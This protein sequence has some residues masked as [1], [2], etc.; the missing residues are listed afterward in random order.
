V[1]SGE[2]NFGTKPS[3]NGMVEARGPRP[4][5]IKNQYET[6]NVPNSYRSE[7]RNGPPKDESNGLETINERTEAEENHRT[8][9]KMNNPG[10]ISTLKALKNS[11]NFPDGIQSEEASHNPYTNLTSRGTENLGPLEDRSEESN[12]GPDF[13]DS[14]NLDGNP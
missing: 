3:E 12:Q 13:D 2:E 8:V 1:S 11:K 14:Y 10:K 4:N 7:N 9:T 5:W 6:D